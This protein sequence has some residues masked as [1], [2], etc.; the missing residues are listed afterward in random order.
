MYLS[1]PGNLS[2]WS[3]IAN[4]SSSGKIGH[5]ETGRYFVRDITV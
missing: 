5:V 1:L 2:L 3:V 4:E